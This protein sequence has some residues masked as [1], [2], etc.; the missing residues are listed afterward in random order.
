MNSTF[1][2]CVKNKDLVIS[3]YAKRYP[4]GQLSVISYYAKRYPL[5]KLSVISY[6]AKRYPL[7]Q[8]SSF[9]LNFLLFTV[10]CWLF[11]DK[12]FISD[13]RHRP[14]PKSNAETNYIERLNNILRQCISWL[15][16]KT[17]SFFK[18]IDN[19]IRVFWYFIHRYN[20][21]ICDS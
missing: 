21:V 3:Y 1:V 11:T 6:Y 9:A 12:T 14:V 5:G 18:E 10:D 8:L 17:L 2:V 15:V 4:L 13:S 7:G 16:K 19:H 20:T